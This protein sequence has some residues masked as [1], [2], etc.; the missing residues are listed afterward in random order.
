MPAEPERVLADH[1]DIGEHVPL[2][3]DLAE[4]C[5]SVVEFGV[6]K[7]V[8]T[9]ALVSSVGLW[10]ISYDLYPCAQ[11]R[12]DAAK[13]ARRRGV[14]FKLNVG[15]SREAPTV[16][17]DMLFIDSEHTYSC[18]RAELERHGDSVRKFIAM[19]DTELFG[20]EGT[21]GKRPGLRGAIEEWLATRPEWS[22]LYDLPNCC[23]LMVLER[24]GNNRV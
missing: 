11:A 16:D 14:Y 22:V 23:G 20:L 24:E 2:L 1:S 12:E 17:T 18:M 4:Q 5:K 9:R 13:I 7:G 6:R 21:D 10:M 8:S 15:D 19:H 3:Q